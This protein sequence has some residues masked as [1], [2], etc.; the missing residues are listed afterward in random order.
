MYD[1]NAV[2]WIKSVTR[3]GGDSWAYM[4]HNVGDIFALRF[5]DNPVWFPTNYSRARPNDLM[6]L[7]QT[8]LEGPGYSAGTYVTHLVTP[9]DRIVEIDDSLQHPYKRNVCVVGRTDPAYRVNLTEWSFYKP[10]RGQICD[11]AR[12][13]RRGAPDHDLPAKRAFLWN[14]FNLID[15]NLDAAISELQGPPLSEEESVT[16]GAD[17]VYLRLHKAR[18]RNARIVGQAKARARELDRFFVRYA[19]LILKRD[20][21]YWAMG[22]LNAI[23]DYRSPQEESG[24]KTGGSGF[25]VLELP[26]D[27]A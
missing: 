19:G 24:D 26:S 3:G 11:I 15:S 2:R 21:R 9:V 5:P 23:T 16:E 10:N 27:V 4:E 17:L 1:E 18:E 20:F 6:V 25:G 7:F 14:M 8:L 12:I 22:S 13:E